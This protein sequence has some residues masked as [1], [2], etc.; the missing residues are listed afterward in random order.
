MQISEL[1]VHCMPQYYKLRVSNAS[2]RQPHQHL[3]LGF[4]KAIATKPL[5]PP[6]PRNPEAHHD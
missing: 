1:V 6:T 5:N 3:L 4:E 2:D